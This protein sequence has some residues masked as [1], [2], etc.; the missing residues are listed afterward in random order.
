MRPGV[1][2]GR[3]VLHRQPRR[4][5]GGQHPHQQRHRLRV[6]VGDE[7][8]L[9]VGAGA[10]DPVEVGGERRP[11]LGRAAAV[12]VAEPVVGR[13]GEDAAHRPQPC[14]ARERR[15]V[16]AAVAEVDGSP[17]RARGRGPRR[18]GASGPRSVRAPGP[19][20]AP[21][22]CSRRC[23]SSGNPRRRAGRRPRRPPRARPPG[24]SPGRGWGAA[25]RRPAALPSGCRSRIEASIWRC[26]ASPPERSSSIASSETGDRLVLEPATKTDLIN[27]TAAWRR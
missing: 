4:A 14:R 12:E 9:G 11:Q 8:R 7:D 2:G 6:A 20:S 21:P 18:S 17:W 26:S 16:A 15:E 10:A 1:V 24:R 23:G 13:L 25:R 27:R 22:A 3:R 5:A 19:A